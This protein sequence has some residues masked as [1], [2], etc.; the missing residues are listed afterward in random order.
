MTLSAMFIGCDGVC[1]GCS[2]D[3]TQAFCYALRLQEIPQC[4]PETLK[5]L[6]FSFNNV[7]TL[8]DQSFGNY[9]KLENLNLDSN[10]ISAV[11]NN[12]FSGLVYLKA[13]SLYNNELQTM[14]VNLFQNLTS[15]ESLNL[16]YNR[17]ITFDFVY[18]TPL[19]QLSSFFVYGNLI[20]S[21][22]GISQN[23]NLKILDLSINFLTTLDPQQLAQNQN[24]TIWLERNSWICSCETTVLINT[25]HQQNIRIATDPVCYG[26][27]ELV[28]TPWNS[29]GDL[30]TN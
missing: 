12:V 1:M 23:K 13:L 18:L 28:G 10:G 29:L 19:T 11:Q 6:N 20:D 21:I 15:L 3:D 24:M 14:P 9:L 25:F 5:I 22:A 8:E 26:P 16:A 30:C 4:L 7:T 17:F 27:P 2:Y